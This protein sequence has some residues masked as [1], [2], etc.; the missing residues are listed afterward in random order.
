MAPLE[1]KRAPLEPKR[2]WN[3]DE[4]K[5]IVGILFRNNLYYVIL[6]YWHVNR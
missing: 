6:Y 4:R 3:G 2:E 1:Q 5:R